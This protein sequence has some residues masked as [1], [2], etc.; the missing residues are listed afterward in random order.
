MDIL[1]DIV[2]ID[3][4]NNYKNWA[5]DFL[6]LSGIIEYTKG[7]KVKIAIID[8][9]INTNHIE[10]K[11]KVS[12]VSNFSVYEDS[13][14]LNGHGTMIASIIAG[15]NIGVAPNAELYMAKSLNRNGDG[16][17]T[18]IYQGIIFAINHKVDI[19]CMSLGMVKEAPK[20]IKQ[21]ID[22]AVK[23]GITVVCASGNLGRNFAS[24]PARYDNVIGVGGLDKDGQISSFSNKGEGV[25]V[26]A[27][28]EYVPVAYK[29][30]EYALIS[31]TS[32]ANAYVVGV[33]ALI[34]SY[35]K[36]YNNTEANNNDIFNILKGM[37][38][39]ILNANSILNII[40]NGE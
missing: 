16:T 12:K 1:N 14:D 11:D 36:I 35:Y 27:P 37:D 21:A 17:V 9:G 4:I 13:E 10:I 19:L 8:S 25:D 38:G 22:R 5:L 20:G 24:Y 23:E 2:V 6:D 33:I 40:K 7:D 18:D 32:F 15:E 39:N 34:K 3:D 26:Y 29:D 28:S 30:N 31:G